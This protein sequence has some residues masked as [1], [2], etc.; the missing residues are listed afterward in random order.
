MKEKCPR[1][2]LETLIPDSAFQSTMRCTNCG[3]GVQYDI[4]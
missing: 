3:K 1:C 4:I 2:K